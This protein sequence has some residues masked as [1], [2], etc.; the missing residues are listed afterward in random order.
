V[1]PVEGSAPAATGPAKAKAGSAEEREA[2]KAV[3]RIDKQ[4]ERLAVREAELH[5]AMAEAVTN[6]ERL[7]Q[8]GAELDDVLAEKADLELEWLEAAEVLE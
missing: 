8:L 5:A 2:K 6:Y 7:A 3:A 1:S 4:L